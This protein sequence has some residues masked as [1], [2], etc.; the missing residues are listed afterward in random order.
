MQGN[1]KG[2]YISAQTRADTQKKGILYSLSSTIQKHN[3]WLLNYI[4]QHLIAVYVLRSLF[5]PVDVNYFLLKAG[6]CNT[7]YFWVLYHHSPKAE[8]ITRMRKMGEHLQEDTLQL[9]ISVFWPFVKENSILTMCCWKNL[10]NAHATLGRCGQVLTLA[11]PLLVPPCELWDTPAPL[12]LCYSRHTSCVLKFSSMVGDFFLACVGATMNF[13][14]NCTARQI[15]LGCVK[16]TSAP[17][18][19]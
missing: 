18:P 19:G 5:I 15:L 4:F 6:V 12:P 1:I 13:V 11:K 8:P 10:Y 14:H 3:L 9:V 16:G 17:G 7:C 2:A